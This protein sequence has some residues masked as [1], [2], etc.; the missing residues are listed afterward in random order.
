MNDKEP[1][2][3]TIKTPEYEWDITINCD[4]K[5]NTIIKL[6]SGGSVC[7]IRARQLFRDAMQ[8]KNYEDK[9]KCLQ[10]ENLH[11][12][13]WKNDHIDSLERI[14]VRLSKQIIRQLEIIRK[15]EERR[16]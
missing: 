9:I 13:E 16:E 10:E 12:N 5:I 4:Q 3:R 11:I 14:R 2:D 8:T 6:I 7:I 15:Y 1:E